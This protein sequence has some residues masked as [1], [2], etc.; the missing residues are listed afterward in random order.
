MDSYWDCPIARS[1]VRSS[2][3][4]LLSDGMD[5]PGR[6]QMDAAVCLSYEKNHPVYVPFISESG[7]AVSGISWAFPG[8]VDQHQTNV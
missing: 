3:C 1:N 2:Q 7:R 6:G 4:R 8:L 5:C